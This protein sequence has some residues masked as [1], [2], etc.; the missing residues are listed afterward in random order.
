ME[1]GEK[2]FLEKL[3]YALGVIAVILLTVVIASAYTY[4]RVKGRIIDPN[5]SS[6]APKQNS[7]LDSNEATQISE[8]LF[9]I[10]EPSPDSKETFATPRASIRTKS[11]SSPLRF[12]QSDGY[13]FV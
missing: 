11:M 7:M 6:K 5:A 13:S 9:P 4:V 8:E 12:M 10:V 2:K 3:K 1:Q